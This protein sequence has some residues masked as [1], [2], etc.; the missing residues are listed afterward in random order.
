VPTTRRG[1][2]IELVRTLD[3]SHDLYL[4]DHVLSG[5][6]VLPMAVGCALVAEAAALAVPGMELVGVRDLMVLRGIVLEN[7]PRTVLIRATPLAAISE[8]VE[9]EVTISG[10]DDPRNAHYRA[11]AEFARSFPEP[12][13]DGLPDLR[14]ARRF[15]VS[16]DEAYRWLFHGPRFRGV[17]TI[18]GMAGE[19]I[20]GSIMP[21]SPRDLIAGASESSWVVDPVVVDSAL[22]LI[23]FWLRVH[24]DVAAL[25]SGFR[26]YRRFGNLPAE[27]VACHTRIW[28]DPTS[29]IIHA[30]ILLVG[31]GGRMLGLME[32]MEGTC[33]KALIQVFE[34]A[35]GPDPRR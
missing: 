24:W 8:R 25:P 16:V 22:Q 7:G 33:S 1:D 6:P 4:Q 32:D 3:P 13:S 21:S 18:D 12:P 2:T 27:P 20:S 11:V 30:D 23:L 19:W 14:E 15:P 31:P 26:H 29:H 34:E 5:K 9:V 17:R 35:P 28:G 10:T